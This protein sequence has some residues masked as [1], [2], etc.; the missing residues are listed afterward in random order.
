MRSALFAVLWG[1]LQ[2]FVLAAEWPQFRGPK[3]DGVAATAKLPTTWSETDN[4]RWKADTPGRGWSSPVVADGRIWLTSALERS[5]DKDLREKLR[6]EKFSRNPMKAELNIVG[7]ISLRL[8]GFDAETG[9]QILDRELLS[10]KLPQP[11]HSLNSYASPTPVWHNGRLYCHFGTYGTV[12][13]DIEA[14]RV[15]WSK[16]L[17]LEHSVGPG[18]SPVIVAERLIIPCDGADQQYVVAL[19]AETGEEVWKMPRPPMTGTIG[20]LHKA[21]CTPLVIDVDGK[22]QAVVVGAQWVVSYDPVT[23]EEIWKVRHG[24][25]FSNVPRPVFG[26]GMIFM[27]TGFTRPE[28]W[29]IRVDGKGDVTKTHVVWKTNKQIPTMPSPVLVG[30]ELYFVNDQGIASCLD[31]LTGA[32]HWQKRV[33]GNYCASAWAADGKV[34]FANREGKTTVVRASSR[35]DHLADNFL[36]GQIFATPAIVG[37]ALILR[38]DAHLYWIEQEKESDATRNR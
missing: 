17:P 32:P 37:D 16:D 26:H 3:G 21:F 28:M 13:Y 4:V 9:D 24:E 34:Y 38:T 12:C 8:I 14:A 29:A 15:V 36:E 10:V 33:E 30:D 35:Y 5:L 19:D 31:A 1:L 6:A 25:G 23:G 18:S 22:K 7:E 20:D 2:T 11:V 27:S